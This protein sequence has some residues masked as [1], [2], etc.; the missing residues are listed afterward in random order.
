[1]EGASCVRVMGWRP[2]PGCLPV[3][4]MLAL[5]GWP[6]HF[7]HVCQPGALPSP[8]QGQPACPPRGGPRSRT[9]AAQR[10]APRPCS[11]SFTP[12]C[13]ELPPCEHSRAPTCWT[14]S[15]SNQWSQIYCRGSIPSSFGQKRLVSKN[16]RMSGEVSQIEV[17]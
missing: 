15:E 10:R 3:L 4:C 11:L 1:M 7:E 5:A 13:T 6:L 2:A 8:C 9:G 14:P 16:L 17:G 12:S